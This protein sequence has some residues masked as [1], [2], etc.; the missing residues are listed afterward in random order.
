LKI[1]RANKHI[2][3]LEGV[4]LSLEDTYSSTVERDDNV[5]YQK[6][7][8]TFPEV[9]TSLAKLSLIVGDAIHNLHAALDFAYNRTLNQLAPS[10]VSGYAKFPVYPTRE[11]LE[12]VLK[13][14]KI[15][16]LCPPLFKV[17]VSEIQPYERGQAGVVYALHKLDISDKHLLLLGLT[18]NAHIKGIILQK[19]GGQTTTAN[20][21]TMGGAGSYAI[22]FPRQVKI[23]DKGKLRVTITVQEAGI[24]KG[25]PVLDL[26]SGFSQY[27]LYVVQRLESL[28]E[29]EA[30]SSGKPGPRNDKSRSS[31]AAC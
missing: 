15:D 14:R 9:E 3:E 10:A 8:H 11:Q 18:P 12:R 26:L 20:T 25:L 24:F 27:V 4:I 5:G 16:T 7:I 31:S 28:A 22:A 23:K 13:G 19:K 17:I 29:K 1:D 21:M 2:A 6:L 30:D